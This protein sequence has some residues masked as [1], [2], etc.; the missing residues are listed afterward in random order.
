MSIYSRI[1]AFFAKR[2]LT[3]ISEWFFVTFDDKAVQMRAGPPGEKPWS[4]EFAW[5]TVTRICFEA[6][7]V[8]MSDGIYVFTTQRPG[9][10]VI[11][12][13]AQGGAELWGEILRRKLF[14][15]ELAIKAACST[16]GLY[17]WPP[18]ESPK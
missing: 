1:K 2:R 15:A 5:D 14:D 9:S 6:N 7:D 17:C 3:P 4:Q 11:P 13:E 10:Y 18:R 16:G 8:Y 12:T